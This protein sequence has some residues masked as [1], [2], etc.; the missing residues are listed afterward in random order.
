MLVRQASEPESTF[1]TVVSTHRKD[2]CAKVASPESDVQPCVSKPAL[3]CRVREAQ[4]S[5]CRSS[6]EN[7]CTNDYGTHKTTS[8][9]PGTLG[10]VSGSPGGAV[11][12]PRASRWTDRTDSV[13]VQV[14]GLRWRPPPPPLSRKGHAAVILFRCA[15]PVAASV[16]DRPLCGLW[17]ATKA[18]GSPHSTP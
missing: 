13:R 1:R 3:P 16:T 12:A 10:A 9:S 18:R 8:T 4:L 2:C 11:C 15:S 7:D 6:A 5:P 17:R 14:L